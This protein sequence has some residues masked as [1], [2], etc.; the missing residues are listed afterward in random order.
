ML[1]TIA[2][3][4]FRFSIVCFLSTECRIHRLKLRTDTFI[5]SKR[6]SFISFLPFFF[7]ISVCLNVINHGM[8]LANRRSSFNRAP[9]I[10]FLWLKTDATLPAPRLSDNCN[11]KRLSI[12]SSSSRVK[13][14]R[15]PS[16]APDTCLDYSNS[17]CPLGQTTFLTRC[18]NETA[19]PPPETRLQRQSPWNSMKILHRDFSVHPLLKIYTTLFRRCLNNVPK[20]NL[21]LIEIITT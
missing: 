20:N 12:H 7:V 5:L 16:G 2:I 11:V 8:L 1:R 9:I 21:E 4:A 10:H 6:F 19:N 13:R 17:H 14:L 3:N 18:R 15:R